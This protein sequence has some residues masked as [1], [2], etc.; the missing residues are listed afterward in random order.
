MKLIAYLR[1]STDKQ[2]EEGYGL[3]VQ[4][5]D[6]KQ[7]AKDHGHKI[8]DVLTDDGVSGSNGLDT[9]E[10]LP[11][12]LLALGAGRASGLLIP[13]LDRLSRDM[14]LQEQL[15]R[16]VWS[17]GAE[18]FSALGSEQNL[19]DDP[20]DPG[21]KMLRQI[22]GAVNEYERSIIVLRLRKGRAAKAARGG[23]AYGSPAFGQR[24]ADRQLVTDE[25]E[26]EVAA[27]M[28]AMRA[29]GLSLREIAAAL[30]SAGRKPKRGDVWHPVTVSRVLQRARKTTAA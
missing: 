21:R 24:A 4:A 6:V 19:R 27:E 25:R 12:A 14:L 8:V 9:R 5:A 28:A 1:V 7:W 20:D 17:I 22:L 30:N 29:N 11:E 2:A 26:A 16:E 18:V 3:D 15:L 13:K 23:Y 10:A